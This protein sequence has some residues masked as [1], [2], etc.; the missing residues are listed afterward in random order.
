MKLRFLAGPG[1][2]FLRFAWLLSTANAVRVAFAPPDGPGIWAG[3]FHFAEL[4]NLDDNVAHALVRQGRGWLLPGS[5]SH[6]AI[7]SLRGC[8]M[9]RLAGREKV[10]VELAFREASGL[11]I[12]MLRPWPTVN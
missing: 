6:G 12:P 11:T 9:P 2:P 4:M 1:W 3:L 8:E 10:E 5:G 7:S